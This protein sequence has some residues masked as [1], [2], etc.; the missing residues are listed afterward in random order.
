MAIA[1]SKLEEAIRQLP[2][3]EKTVRDILSLF[4]SGELD[5]TIL[6]NKI[7]Q[8]QA[9]TVRILRVA[10]SSFYG[11]TGQIANVKD[12]CIVLGCHTI[13]NIVISTAVIAQFSPDKSNVLDRASLWQHAAATGGIARYLALQSGIDAESA[14]TAGLLHD[15]GKLALDACFPA[16][17][18]TTLQYCK[19]HDCAT[20]EAEQV[21]LGYDHAFV[22]KRVAERW[23][24]PAS[25]VNAIA[26]HHQPS[27]PALQFVDVVHVADIL[28]RGIGIGN[29]PDT[30]IGTIDLS[31]LERLNIDWTLIRQR[32]P[33]IAMAGKN[34]MQFI[35]I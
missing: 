31:A 29:C 35:Q 25:L 1:L 5:L 12:A 2:A 3:F 34:A 4:E 16:E 22:G 21:V 32:L 7:M 14:F 11:F 15:I 13:R 27:S 30:L 24:L 10:N 18:Q 26:F 33:E 8:D 28:G 17:Y 6:Q 23:K 19:Q 9:L 20:R